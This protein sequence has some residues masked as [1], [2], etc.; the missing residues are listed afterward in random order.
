MPLYP[1]QLQSPQSLYFRPLLALVLL[2][3]VYFCHKDSYMIDVYFSSKIPLLQR[4]KHRAFGLSN[5]RK[6]LVILFPDYI[7]RRKFAQHL[8]SPYCRKCQLR[9]DQLCKRPRP[10]CREG[11]LKSAYSPCFPSK[12]LLHNLHNTT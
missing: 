8:T 11:A 4:L 1:W 3:V 9:P 6:S 10:L 2:T 12:T 7:A 5:A